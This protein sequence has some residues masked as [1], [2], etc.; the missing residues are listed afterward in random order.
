MLAGAADLLQQRKPT[1]I[2]ELHKETFER[3]A[4]EILEP[5]GYWINVL[6]PGYAGHLLATCADRAKVG[7]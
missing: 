7:P 4:G 2:I 3:R 5:L 1:M 6:R